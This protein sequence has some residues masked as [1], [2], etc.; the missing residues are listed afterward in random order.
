[1]VVI[2]PWACI[3]YPGIFPGCGFTCGIYVLL[4]QVK[5]SRQGDTV[6]DEELMQRVPHLHGIARNISS[7]RFAGLARENGET[8]VVVF[9][10]QKAG[11][12]VIQALDLLKEITRDVERY[13]PS[14]DNWG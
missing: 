11:E 8:V 5:S 9:L 10:T 12:E 13:H 4:H 1:M 2:N 6:F 7:F 14:G 3:M